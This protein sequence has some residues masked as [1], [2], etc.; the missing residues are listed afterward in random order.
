MILFLIEIIIIIAIWEIGKANS[1]SNIVLLLLLFSYLLGSILFGVII[2]KI[3]NLGDITKQGSKNVGAT[4]IARVSGNK[5]LG[6]V[7][8]LLDGLKGAIPIIMTTQLFYIDND[9]LTIIGGAA[10]LGHIFP[11]WHKFKGGKGV[12]TFLGMILALNL[13]GDYSKLYLS[14]GS[15]WIITFSISRISSLSSLVMLLVCAIKCLLCLDCY[16]AKPLLAIT[17]IVIFKHKDN[18]SRLI[19]GTE[20]KIR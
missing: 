17:L 5:K 11:I 15:A 12:A 14:M 1:F 20:G 13:Q 7:V 16:S 9:S 18:I 3:M 4:N 19:N 8:A 6:I 2:A 10:V